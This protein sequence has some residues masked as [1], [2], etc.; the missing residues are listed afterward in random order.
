MDDVGGGSRGGKIT[1]R[2]EDC[3][4][5]KGSIFDGLEENADFGV[6]VIVTGRAQ[7]ATKPVI[8]EEGTHAY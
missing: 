3:L 8:A 2:Q 5:G 6:P 7:G 4:R 1:V